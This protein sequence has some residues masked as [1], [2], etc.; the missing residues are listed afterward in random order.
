MA[1][2]STDKLVAL[3]RAFTEDVMTPRPAAQAVAVTYGTA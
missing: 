2:L 1:R 3:K